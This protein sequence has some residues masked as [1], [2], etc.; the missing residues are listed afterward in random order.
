MVSTENTSC[1]S[2]TFH[3]FI[4]FGT[5]VISAPVMRRSSEALP[6]EPATRLQGSSCA[7]RTR[8]SRCSAVPRRSSCRPRP[9][10]ALPAA[11]EESPTRDGEATVLFRCSV[12]LLCSAVPAGGGRRPGRYRT[13]CI[14]NCRRRD[15]PSVIGL[16]VCCL[17]TLH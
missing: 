9:R 12:R 10:S 2:L 6:S 5:N 1:F 16:H 8:A 14:P 15:R 17:A 7:A 11:G 3:T 4:G 13:R